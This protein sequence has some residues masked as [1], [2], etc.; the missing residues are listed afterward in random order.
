[1]VHVE[2]HD[3][4]TRFEFSTWRSRAIGYSV[5]AYLVRGVLVDTG[6]HA[7]RRDVARLV[8]ELREASD[9]RRLRGAVVTH[10]HED[11]AGNVALLARLGV[12]LGIAAA[13]R[14]ALRTVPPIGFYRRYTWGSMPPLPD[15]APTVATLDTDAL[16]AFGL[17]LIAT[18]GHS[19][20]HHA[21]WDAERETLFGGDLF[22]GVKVRVAH[23]GEDPRRLVE[24]LRAV[25]ALRP[26]RLFDAHRGAVD[27]ATAKLAA[28]ASWIEEAIGEI[29]RLAAAGWSDAAIRTQVLGRE[30]LAG[31][32]SRGDYS[33]G[34][35]VRAV[36]R[37]GSAAPSTG[38]GA[39]TR[40]EE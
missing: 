31:Y 6:F 5:S 3:D 1:M 13:T 34:N 36:R 14:E 11:H 24:T 38:T 27:D 37:T 35:F 28:K 4:V 8:A 33:R 16:A 9:E 22:L 21:V 23:P 2:R 7:V 17:A 10:K 26:K 19:A 15:D 30:A 39:G 18:P 20:D 12:P 25:A 29:D 40:N 32:F